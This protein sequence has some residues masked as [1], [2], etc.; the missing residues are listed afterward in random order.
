M[1]KL[2]LL[3]IL[4]GLLFQQHFA[5]QVP[6]Y[7]QYILN[8]FLVNP[9]VAGIDGMTSINTTGRKQW[10]GLKNAPE[11]Y[12]LTFSGRVLKSPF[13]IRNRKYRKG[14]KGRV[15]LGGAF[16]SDW[17]GAINRTS[18]QFTYAYHIFIQN[19]Q[20]SFGLSANATQ[21]RIDQDLITLRDPN[22]D[23]VKNI[24]DKSAYIPD[25]GAGISYSSHNGIIGL[26]VVNLLQ[27][28]IKFGNQEIR[29]QELDHIRQYN[30][31]GVYKLRLKNKYWEIEPSALLRGNENL[32]FSADFTG[33]LIYKKEYWAGLSVRTTGDFI[34]LLGM[35]I[36]RFYVGYSFD[37][38]VNELSRVSYGSHE[39]VLALK[40]GDSARRY[41]WLERY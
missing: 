34:L 38:G 35:K 7:S 15:G 16:I 28:P 3:L 19:N 17:N 23:P 29:S 31:Y 25:A 41:R 30:L 40:L 5:Q 32:H 39:I 27:S 13:S 21:F 2:L 18:L 12:S 6:I 9:A 22:N 37:Y 1:R 11:T 33:R 10:I 20:L 8:E 36:N 4:S 14:S 26:S 24:L